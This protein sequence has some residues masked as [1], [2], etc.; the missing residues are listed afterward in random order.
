MR[1]ITLQ[2]SHIHIPQ[3]TLDAI[4]TAAA[5][6]AENG[7]ETA[8]QD[9][10]DTW[11]DD[12]LR[13]RINAMT[14]TWG[15]E[16]LVTGSATQALNLVLD[17]IGKGKTLAVNIPVYFGVLRKAKDLGL[18]VKTWE[19][20]A[21]LGALGAFDAVLLS[22]NFTPPAGQ[23]FSPAD[24]KTIADIAAKNDAWLI[25]DNAYDPIWF[26]RFPDP[27]A[28]NPD[29]T[30]RVCSLSKIAAPGFRLGFI[31]ANDTVMEALRSAKITMD[32]SSS[33]IPQILARAALEPRVLAAF[34]ADVHERVIALADA[35]RTHAGV[36][37]V[38]PQGGPFIRLDLPPE[39]AV[40]AVQGKLRALNVK[41]D[42]N[43]HYYPDGLDRPFIRL[44]AGAAPKEDLVTAA[45]RIAMALELVRFDAKPLPL[46]HPEN[47]A[48][49][50]LCG[51]TI[52][53][54]GGQTVE[55]IDGVRHFTN[56]ARP[57]GQGHHLAA[58]LAAQGAK[59]L[60]LAAATNIDAPDGV[61][62]I[63]RTPDG[64][65]IRSTQ[66]LLA[67]A[68]ALCKAQKF[69]AVMTL[70]AVPSCRPAIAAHRKMKVKKDDHA[71][72]TLSVIPNTSPIDFLRSVTTAPVSGFDQYQDFM[73][74]SNDKADDVT[75]AAIAVYSTLRP[76][77]APM[78][79]QEIIQAT[80]IDKDIDKD[81]D[82]GIDTGV[83]LGDISAA[84]LHGRTVIVT[85]GTTHEAIS[86]TGDIITNFA[87][88]RQGHAVALALA[89]MGANVTLVTGPARVALPTH[90]N[91]QVVTVTN[92]QE[93][94]AAC[95]DALPADAAVCVCAVGDFKA[96]NPQRRLFENGSE[97]QQDIILLQN[98]DTLKTLG[99]HETLR[100]R[101][102]IGFAAET[103][104]V[105]AYGAEK[106]RKKGADAIFANQVGTQNIA[107][108]A[109]HNTVHFIS[110]TMTAAWGE[111]PKYDIG[112]RIGAA[113]IALETS[114]EPSA[115]TG[116]KDAN[117]APH[118]D[119]PYT[120]KETTSRTAFVRAANG[121]SGAVRAA[122]RIL[123]QWAQGRGRRPR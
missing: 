7:I 113:I 75:K 52:L 117:P 107:R 101:V 79:R 69:D 37:P 87:S 49:A 95:V 76:Q 85:S 91:I 45:A 30:V 28:Y 89:N 18:T 16:V 63:N 80:D 42:A 93:L 119:H 60:L 29:K 21:D 3:T 54:T 66:D 38:M 102:V 57:Q 123:P 13:R 23:S 24:K 1:D 4:K 104:D 51:K 65:K 120:Q 97:T 71:P 6:F 74:A 11:G 46:P 115:N 39:Y 58:A 72:I 112:L 99:L 2:S 22:S 48:F 90:D 111:C 47:A 34:R 84:A 44:N 59:V 61:C 100:P 82:T 86:A 25:E 43:G 53:V 108:D 56:T 68:D 105:A 109:H 83:L 33:I 27:I 17:S 36:T 122:L 62:V 20:A 35:L 14:P 8:L 67:T 26:D 110:H 78:P 9:Y 41:A 106:L 32:L 5:A 94:Q 103:H 92:A 40:K 31:K 114:T 15:G 19:S 50:P 10:P 81:I 96:S 70:A 121:F 64:Q 88:G 118:P 77:D 12:V 98:P 55:S 116:E 73:A